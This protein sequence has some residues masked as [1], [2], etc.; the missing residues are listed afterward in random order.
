MFP[1]SPGGFGG[2]PPADAMFENF[3]GDE[4]DLIPD[5]I[6]AKTRENEILT[7]GLQFFEKIKKMK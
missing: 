5:A 2:P 7:A 1:G 4:D 3:L 6:E